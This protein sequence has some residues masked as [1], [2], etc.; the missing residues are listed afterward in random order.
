MVSLSLTVLYISMMS[1]SLTVLYISMRFIFY[2]RLNFSV[3]IF[4]EIDKIRFEPIVD[5]YEA[6][7]NPL[8]SF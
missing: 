3:T 7:V 4:H 6:K 2:N 5:S 1:L 8:K